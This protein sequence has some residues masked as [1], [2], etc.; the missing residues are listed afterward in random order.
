M[1]WKNVQ[2]ENGRLRTSS[3]GSGGASNFADL[4]DVDLSNLQDGQVP[5]YNTTTEKWEN[6]DI[7]LSNYVEKEPGKGLS[8]NDYS[9]NDKDTVARIDYA[10]TNITGNPLSFDVE[11]AQ[12]ASGTVITLNPT[13]SGINTIEILGCGVNIWDE[14]WEI[15]S[16]SNT[17]TDYPTSTSI[18]SKNYCYIGGDGDYYISCQSVPVD[19]VVTYFYD[20][21][22]NFIPYIGPDA[23][24]NGYNGLGPFTAPTGAKYFRIRGTNTYGTTY[25]NDICLCISDPTKNGQYFPY[26]PATNIILPLGQTV[27]GGILNLKKGI[28]TTTDDNIIQLTPHELLLLQGYNYI[29]T[30]C[31]SID[32]YYKADGDEFA[33]MEDIENIMMIIN[34][35][36]HRIN[37]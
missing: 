17:G 34:E 19:N 23:Y 14:Q 3:G 16:I 31:D 26:T 18:R 29:S 10:K 7:D 22:K 9:D 13:L 12:M 28:F 1:A 32:T 35:L 27:Y 4:E 25:K 24:Q 36:S 6:A 15:G 11:T 2:Y 5:K 33:S 37:T 21:N 20:G 30:N 8:T